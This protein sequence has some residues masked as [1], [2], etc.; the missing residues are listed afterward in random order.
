MGKR[1]QRKSRRIH[2]NASCHKVY[3][4]RGKTLKVDEFLW[5]TANPKGKMMD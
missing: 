4:G 3:Q 5:K 1:Q 2:R